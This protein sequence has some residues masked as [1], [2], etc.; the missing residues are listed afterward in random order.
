MSLSTDAEAATIR[1]Q[2]F[3]ASIQQ[4]AQEHLTRDI[5][6]LS[7]ARAELRRYETAADDLRQQLVGTA[8]EQPQELDGVAA[9]YAAFGA[10]RA[11]IALAHEALGTIRRELMERGRG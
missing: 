11:D 7:E 9:L 8:Y 2:T 1:L 10:M 5:R 6:A 3:L 4:V